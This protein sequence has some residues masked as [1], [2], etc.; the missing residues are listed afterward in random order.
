MVLLMVS[1]FALN[2][3]EEYTGSFVLASA[4]NVI[5][6]EVSQAVLTNPDCAGGYLS[7]MQ[8]SKADNTI[9]VNVVG[10]SIDLVKIAGIINIQMCGAS[11][12][13]GG[14]TFVCSG[15]TYTLSQV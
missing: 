8:F 15:T 11:S 13:T 12:T 6:S 7:S 10:C 5:N 14:L 2:I 9:R 4:K 3:G 1:I